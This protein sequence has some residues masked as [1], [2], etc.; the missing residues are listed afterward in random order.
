MIG[1]KPG[2]ELSQSKETRVP[3]WGLSIPNMIDLYILHLY[4]FHLLHFIVE[5]YMNPMTQLILQKSVLF[6]IL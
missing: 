3:K 5:M 6:S 4:L 1:R 2:R